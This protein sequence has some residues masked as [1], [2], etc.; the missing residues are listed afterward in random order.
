[1]NRYPCREPRPSALDK[2]V[3]EK[4]HEIIRSRLRPHYQEEKM[5]HRSDC[6][7]H[8]APAMEPGE[9]DCGAEEQPYRKPEGYRTLHET[10]LFAINEVK[11]L[12]EVILRMMDSLKDTSFCDPRL[13]AIAGT[14]FELGFMALVKSI[15]KPERVKLATDDI[16]PP[17]PKE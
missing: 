14:Q 5:E 8:N 17:A 6:A 1:M 2:L 13:L 9:C 3:D 4:K 15:A 10:E 16:Y 7:T 11:Q 12:E